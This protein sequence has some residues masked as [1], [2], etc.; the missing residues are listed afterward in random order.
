VLDE[1]DDTLPVPAVFLGQEENLAHLAHHLA[2]LLW[3][4]STR[5]V[6]SEVHPDAADA[7]AERGVLDL[8]FLP[9]V[10]TC[11]NK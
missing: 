11:R 9:L 4:L 2:V 10:A 7:A 1:R 3:S 5:G 6:V 8:L